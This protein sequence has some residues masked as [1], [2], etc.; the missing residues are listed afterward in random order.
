MV[1]GVGTDFPDLGDQVVHQ[2]AAQEDQV[3]GVLGA[4]VV[5]HGL[6]AA[7]DP[8]HQIP[9]PLAVEG[10]H[11]PLLLEQGGQLG[12]GVGLVLD[13]IVDKHQADVVGQ[14]PEHRRQGFLVP[15][16]NIVVVDHDEGTLAHHGQAVHQLGQGFDVKLLSAEG[17][18]V[19]LLHSGG[20][21]LLFQ[22]PQVEVPQVGL[23]PVKHVEGADAAL[24]DVLFQLLVG[25]S[26]RL[27]F[28]R[29]GNSPYFA[30]MVTVPDQSVR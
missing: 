20:Q 29:H 9:L 8:V 15:L 18:E 6:E 1:G 22:L 7:G 3:L 14:L 12:A 30:V 16:V 27:C 17:V 21:E 13:E 4:D 5:V 11:A 28:G 26:V 10:H 23:L 19:E 24:L 2:I 25:R